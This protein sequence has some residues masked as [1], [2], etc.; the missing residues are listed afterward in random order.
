MA[1][2]NQLCA[3]T[4]AGIEGTIHTVNVFEEHK[5]EDR[6][7]YFLLP[8]MPLTPSTGLLPY[9]TCEFSGPSVLISCLTPTESSPS[10]M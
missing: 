5:I 4:R 8:E 3:G 9:E 2:V 6:E 1:R 10:G 7:S